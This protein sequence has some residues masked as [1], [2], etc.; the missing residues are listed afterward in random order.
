MMAWRE[1]SLGTEAPWKPTLVEVSDSG[2]RAWIG[3]RMAVSMARNLGIRDTWNL[4]K[5]IGEISEVQSDQKPPEHGTIG[6]KIPRSSFLKGVVGVGVGIAVLANVPAARAATAEDDLSWFATLKL[7][8]P[9]ELSFEDASREMNRALDL[10]ELKPVFSDVNSQSVR[11]RERITVALERPA[12]DSEE[13]GVRSVVH[14]IQGG[15]KMTATMFLDEEIS[16]LLYE[17]TGGKN[18]G[19]LYS[20]VL[21]KSSSESADVLLELDSGRVFSRPTEAE[22]HEH[23]IISDQAAAGGMTTLAATAT[24][25]SRLNC[26]AKGA[27]YACRCASVNFTCAANCCGPCAFGCSKSWLVWGCVGCVLL[28]CP[29]CAAMNRCCTSV[30]CDWRC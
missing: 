1:E 30:F 24:S 12:L 3:G 7:K 18:H 22:I 25:C 19:R 8:N 13:L 21:R 20:R 15:G 2:T 16:F 14:T 4:L 27:C 11:L 26:S 9:R 10:A 6:N 28:W 23:Q 5:I 17:I 29:A